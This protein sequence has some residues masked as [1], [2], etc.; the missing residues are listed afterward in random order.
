MVTTKRL[1]AIS[2]DAL[3]L[4]RAQPHSSFASRCL[5]DAIGGCMAALA[6]KGPTRAMRAHHALADY[7]A[8]CEHIN[9]PPCAGALS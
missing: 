6:S 3:A 4:I 7:L 1:L 9:T 8:A 5:A 2:H